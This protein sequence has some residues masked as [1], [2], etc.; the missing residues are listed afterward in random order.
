[1]MRC[2]GAAIIIIDFDC[3]SIDG[4]G[5]QKHDIYAMERSTEYVFTAHHRSLANTQMPFF[6]IQANT[7]S[8]LSSLSWHMGH[9]IWELASCE[10]Q[11]TQRCL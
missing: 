9:V 11:V 4:N 2:G 10:T 1:M 8:T 7:L 3:T 5:C 6:D